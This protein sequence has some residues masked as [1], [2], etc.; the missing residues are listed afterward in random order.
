VDSTVA[1]LSEAQLR[2]GLAYYELY[3][4]E[5]E[6]RLAREAAWTPEHTAH[7]LPFTTRGS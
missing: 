7:E 5:I 6:E 2:A 4:A 1:W 3:P